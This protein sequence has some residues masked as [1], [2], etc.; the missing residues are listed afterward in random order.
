MRH[1]EIIVISV[2]E[3]D[4]QINFQKL[5]QKEQKKAIVSD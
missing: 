4:F 2:S 5:I 1:I 3:K